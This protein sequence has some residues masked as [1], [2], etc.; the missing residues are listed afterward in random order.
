MSNNKEVQY[1]CFNEGVSEAWEHLFLKWP[2]AARLWQTFTRIVGVSV[3]F[4][5][6]KYSIYSWWT[7]DYS[8]NLRPLY[9]AMAVFILWQTRKL[10]ISLFMEGSSHTVGWN[11]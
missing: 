7:I 1:C 3:L 10:R 8:I 4:I 2:K 5:Q 9:Q 6:L 11:Y